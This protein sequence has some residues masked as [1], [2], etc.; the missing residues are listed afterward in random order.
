MLLKF[1]HHYFRIQKLRLYNAR[2][3]VL[4]HDNEEF[5]LPKHQDQS[6]QPH[7]DLVSLSIKDLCSQQK[8]NNSWHDS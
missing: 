1:H 8:A 3:K 7:R 5:T 4:G 2:V 6:P